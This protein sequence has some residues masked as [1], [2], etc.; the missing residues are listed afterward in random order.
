M[1]GIAGYIGTDVV[2]EPRVAA[3][4]ER[5]RHRG[6]DRQA[7]RRFATPDGRHAVL[8]HARLSIIDLDARSDQ[9]FADGT[10][11]IVFNGELYNYREVRAALAA[12]GETF[13]TES[14]TEILL[15]A[16]ARGG[17]DALDGCE[18]MWAFAWYDQADG[19]LTLCRDRFGEK[20]LYIHR[21]GTGLYFASEVGALMALA[22]T[23]FPVRTDHL[24][25]YLV[26]GY[27]ALY[28]KSSTFHEG[29]EE[30]PRAQWLRIGLDRRETRGTYWTF[31][32]RSDETMAYADAVAGVRERLVRALDIRLR[33]DVPMAFCMSGGVDSNALIAIARRRLGRDVEGFTV[34]NRD[35]RYDERELTRLSA[36]ELGVRLTEVPVETRDFLPRLRE[37]VGR[38]DAPVYTISYYVHWLLVRSMAE[39]GFRISISGTG[40][41][42]LF[43]GYYDHHLLYLNAVR[44]DPLRYDAAVRAW[45]TH[46]KPLVRNPF[47][48]NPRLFVDAPEFREHI[49]LNV[50]EFRAALTCDFGESF[51]EQIYCPA[52]MRNRMLNELFHESVPVILHEDDLNAMSV[53]IENRSPFLDRP[54]FEFALEIPERHLIRD[55]FTK[56][57]LRDALRGI[58][59]DAVLDDRRKVGFNAPILDLLDI[60][61]ADVRGWLLDDGPIYA[62]VRKPEI[63]RL[64]AKNSLPNSESKF[65]FGF[66]CA[67]M[68][69]EAQ[70]ESKMAAA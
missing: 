18:G 24:M 7:A 60:H 59:P 23:R 8:L 34:V 56:A 40:A 26:Y 52:P 62:H 31:R 13:A 65:L 70:Q 42:E 36:R 46:V 4:L 57:V 27:K 10:Q 49:F 53:S 63:E 19:T 66:V 29:V 12:K 21:D 16:L 64:L 11:W 47:L 5:L 32:S 54:L 1:C 22:G 68:F 20:P 15:R 55:G 61:D 25:R 58:V 14:D 38:H 48:R 28:K 39:A 2:P 43:S 69:L 35:A 6:P 50:D 33:A 44:D 17:L 9:P 37:L 3:C 30:L 67:K 45:E 51:N 41:D